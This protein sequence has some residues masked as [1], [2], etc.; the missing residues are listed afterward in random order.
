M[1][2]VTKP[3][4]I[5][6][7]GD[8]LIRQVVHE[9]VSRVKA[10]RFHGRLEFS[11]DPE[12]SFEWLAV[13]FESSHN[14]PRVLL[15]LVQGSTAHVIVTSRRNRDRGKRLL[16]LEQMR[17]GPNAADIVE[18]FERMVKAARI[19]SQ[20]SPDTWSE[21]RGVWEGLSFETLE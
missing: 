19:W 18:A 13:T 3:S 2:R 16:R 1:I 8:S 6:E 7:F 10:I 11:Y 20:D 15:Q 4:E 12:D 9:F 17:L 21:I 5:S 14:H